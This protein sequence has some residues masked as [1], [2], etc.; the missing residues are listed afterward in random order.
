MVTGAVGL[1]GVVGVVP[2][3]TEIAAAASTDTAV[4]PEAA[5]ATT[6][7]TMSVDV[8]GVLVTTVRNTIVIRSPAGMSTD[9][10][11][12]EVPDSA[13]QLAAPEP[14][15]VHDR[16]VRPAGSRS[17]T[18]T[19]AAVDGPLLPTTIVYTTASPG[20]T[21]STSA[22]LLITRSK[23]AMKASVS[24]ATSLVVSGSIVP[25][26]A[27]TDAVLTMA[28]FAESATVA[29]TVYVTVPPTAT[30]A[31]VE[32]EPVPDE[33]THAEP[34]AAAHVHDTFVR[35]AGTASA[36]AAPSAVEGPALETTMEYVST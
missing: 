34:V 21:T 26:G 25:L 28:A 18:T 15:H 16:A 8:I 33:S 35:P 23:T 31:V 17:S 3:W 7:L 5:V 22:T 13:E 6:T 4:E 30:S 29:T 10:T 27:L 2:G 1:T 9:K 14:E 19:P 12:A 36:I 20:S 11:G 32:I 24:T